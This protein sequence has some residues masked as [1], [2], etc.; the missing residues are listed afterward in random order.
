MSDN[1]NDYRRETVLLHIP[2]KYEENDVIAKNKF[3]ELYE[4]NKDLIFQR[5]RV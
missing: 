5:Q 4:N 3:I 2:F 1:Y